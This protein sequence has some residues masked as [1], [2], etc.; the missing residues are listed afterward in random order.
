[1]TPDERDRRSWLE[2]VVRATQLVRADLDR[3]DDPDAPA[4]LDDLDRLQERLI[5]ELGDH[6]PDR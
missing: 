1:M 4:L 6:D 3:R 5:D 2:R